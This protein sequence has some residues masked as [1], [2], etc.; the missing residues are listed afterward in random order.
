M[1]LATWISVVIFVSAFSELVKM[2]R[3]IGEK[4][5]KKQLLILIRV[6]LFVM[7]RSEGVADR[8]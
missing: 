4:T 1:D 6:L 8:A 5:C 7:K 2:K 3:T